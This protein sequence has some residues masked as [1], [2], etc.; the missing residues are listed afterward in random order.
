MKTI[1]Y[2]ATVA[3][4]CLTISTT[5]AQKVR[6]RDGKVDDLKNITKLNVKFDYSDMT[7]GKKSEKDYI[8]DKKQDYN[9][10]EAGKGD[11]WE[12][13][14]VADREGRFEP[15]FKEEFEKQSG[16][17]IGDYPKEKYT[18]VV[19][20]K[21]S[22]PGFNVGVMR[23]NAEID[24]EAMLVET[25]NPNN[26]VAKLDIDNC[27]G[28]TFFGNDFDTGERLQEAYA[29]AGKGLGKYIKNEV[30]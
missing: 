25:A 2:V 22:E 8:A 12:K 26:V 11:A 21:H 24:C 15:R 13:S 10:N 18:L 20:T 19:K 28:R 29:V 4:I 27:P 6:L 30:K 3:T 5:F 1:L 9:N 7:V 16:I 14:W 17:D 23:H